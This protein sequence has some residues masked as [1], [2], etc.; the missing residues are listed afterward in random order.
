MNG[1]IGSL[2]LPLAPPEVKDV[3]LAHMAQMSGSAGFPGGNPVSIERANF[4]QL[5][6]E[7]YVVCPKTDG[8]RAVLVCTVSDNHDMLVAVVNRALEVFIPRFDAVNRAAFQGTVI[9]LEIVQ[10]VDTGETELLLFD[11]VYVCGVPVANL[12]LPDRLTAV[13]CMLNAWPYERTDTARLCLKKF[14]TSQEEMNADHLL[15]TYPQ[16]GLIMTPVNRPNKFG[17][18][19]VL[20]KWK[21]HHTI[22]FLVSDD[23]CTLLVFDP[24]L[25]LGDHR[26]AG[27]L[28]Q[29]L[30]EIGSI[31]ECEV[32]DAY[33]GIWTFLK[34]R[35]DRS[36]ANDC[37]TFKKTLLNIK[38]R[39]QCAELFSAMTPCV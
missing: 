10:R 30:S 26:V 7:P 36:R 3:V 37:I 8:T 31:V 17:R 11:A 38:E 33:H 19:M 18:N 21:T 6:A 27:R 35:K 5:A 13:K 15:A 25:R 16:D 4:N 22:D 23:G 34:Y 29:P 32:K 20:F 14:Y 39:I 1:Y 9:D 2:E 12:A 28:E 24:A